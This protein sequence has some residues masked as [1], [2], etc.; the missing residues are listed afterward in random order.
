MKTKHILIASMALMLAT[1]CESYLDTAPL[2]Q[3]T[4]ENYFKSDKQLDSYVMAHYPDILNHSNSGYSTLTSTDTNTDDKTFNRQSVAMYT[5]GGGG[6][7]V[8]GSGGLWE[9]A[10]IRKCNYF[11]ERVMPGYEAGTITGSKANIDHYVGEMYFFRAMYYFDKY[12]EV[13]DLPIATTVPQLDFDILVENSIRQPR[14][15]VA[16]FILSDLDK[17]YSLLAE[18][19]PDGNKNRINKKVAALFKSRVALFEGSWLTNFKGTAF[20]PNGPGWTGESTHSSY[21]F[22]AGSIEAEA[23]WFFD[24]AM[25][26]AKIVA[27]AVSLTPQNSTNTLQQSTSEEANPY[28]DMFCETD[29]SGYEEVL[30]WRDFDR[31]LGVSH[32]AAEGACCGNNFAGTTKGLVESFVMANGL[33]IYAAG[34]GYKGDDT[35]NDVVVDRDGRLQLFLKVPGQ[36]N[37][38]YNYDVNSQNPPEEGAPLLFH[39]SFAYVTGY[40]IR[41][42]GKMD[43]DQTGIGQCDT[44]CPLFRGAEAYLNYIE[45]SYM[46]NGSIDADADKY[47]KA[48]R[49]RANVNTDYM[50][51]VNNT[52][53]AK[54]A[55]GD[56]GAYSA[57][58]L[59]DPLLYNIRRERRNELMSE[60][61]RLTDLRRWRSMDQMI[62]TPYIV[63]GFKLWNST[64]TSWYDNADG[65]S[66]LIP[67]GSANANVSSPEDG[68]YLCPLRIQASNMNFDG[69]RWTMAYYLTPI[70]AN[71]FTLTGGE[72]SPIYQNPGW[73]RL[74]GEGPTM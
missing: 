66:T 57:G 21:S 46:K 19:A 24:Q 50:L 63:K 23:E 25:K 60:G 26:S 6:I 8:P 53:M 27:D 48:L 58:Q 37:K 28:F 41:K 73:S 20:V 34:S 56:W 14:T 3:I 17:A 69:Y 11:F 39:Q 38:I 16:R 52:D 29:L 47:W 42:F 51:T 1:S 43:G 65:T 64:M 44:G 62:D 54:E 70:A 68:D 74:G 4:E 55:E 71:H 45:A 67:R 72:A 61:F 9:F 31:G 35:N 5:L 10:N 18:V 2:S 40:A 36:H 15:E 33:P 59:V 13:G 49:Q 30:A 7:T 22:Q 12:K 32:S